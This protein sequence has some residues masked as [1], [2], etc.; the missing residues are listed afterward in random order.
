ME[1][2]RIL[3][4]GSGG[5]REH[6][7][8][9][10]ILSQH[11]NFTVYVIP[12][13]GGINR[14]A[15]RVDLDPQNLLRIAL[16]TKDHDINLTIVTSEMPLTQGVVNEFEKR[17]LTVFG[18]SR[19]AAQVEASKVFLKKL[20]LEA[21]IPTAPFQV[22]SD[23]EQARDYV[24]KAKRPLVIKAD[25]LAAG[26]GVFICPDEKKAFEAIKNLLEDGLLGEAG[27]RIV[28]E[29]LL[30]G[31]EIS[32][33]VITDGKTAIPLMSAQDCKPLFPG[34]P[35]TGGM[36]AYAPVPFMT[37][38]LQEKIMSRIIYPALGA[39][40]R[41]RIVYRGIFYAGLMIIN[42]EP[43]LLEVN[44]RFGD[45]ETQAMVRLWDTDIIEVTQKLLSGK[46][47]E[48]HLRWRPE[49]SV[50]IVLASEGYP[51]QYRTGFPIR[52]LEEAARIPGVMLFHAGTTFRDNGFF[53]SGGR[54]LNVTAIGKDLETARCRALEAASKITFEGMLYRKDIALIA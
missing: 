6:A 35:M 45:P 18:P 9:W 32:F 11:P 2:K 24:R 51:G 1:P 31:R 54:V 26:K 43:Q 49:T 4:I 27:R 42:N 5:G 19:E 47:E 41:Q 39:L 13:N 22:F 15:N 48:V 34:G 40:R 29:E 53:T 14:I 7:L 52:G 16:W 33:F 44:C 28:I 20:A 3:I 17:G 36:G 30:L 12:G 21:G 38:A 37:E 25:G 8:A 10:Q 46:L 23:P 50:C